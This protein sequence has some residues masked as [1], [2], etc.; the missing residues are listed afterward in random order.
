MRINPIIKTDQYNTHRELNS[1]YEKKH[2]KKDEDQDIS[3]LDI[4]ERRKK[5][6]MDGNRR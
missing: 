3:F 1:K 5:N 2:I 6:I 4:L